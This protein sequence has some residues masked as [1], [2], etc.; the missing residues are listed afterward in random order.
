MQFFYSSCQLS[1]MLNMTFYVAPCPA[2]GTVMIVKQKKKEKREIY[3]K[4][5]ETFN[6]IR[7]FALQLRSVKQVGSATYLKLTKVACALV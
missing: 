6:F 2:E 4:A 3:T 7:C 1:N 5:D